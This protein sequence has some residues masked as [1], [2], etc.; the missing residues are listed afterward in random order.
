MKRIKPNEGNETFCMAPWTH[1]YLSPQTERR[2]CCASREPAQSFKQYIDTGN[3]AQEYK[4]LSLEQHWNSKHMRSVRKRMLAGER[5]P[6]CE[7]CDNKLLNTNVYRSYWNKLFQH[8]IDEAFETTKDT[9]ETDMRT[10]SFDYRFNNLCNFKCR[11]CGDMLSSSWEAETRKHKT[12]NIESHPWMASPLKEQIKKF[13]DGQVIREFINAIENKSIREIYWCGGEPLMWD[14]HWKSML[15]IVDLGFSN[16][17]YV[18]YNTNLSRV[19]FGKTKLFD[20]LGNFNDWQVC[21]S[22]DGTGAVGEYIRD[23]LNYKQWLENF[24]QGISVSRNARQM[25]L[26]FTITMPGLLELKNMFDL[27]QELNTEILT[28]VMFTFSNDE[29]LSPLSLPEKLLH[30][31]IDEALEYME[32][33]ATTKQ[34]SLIDVLKNLKNRQTFVPSKKGKSRQEYIDKI[35]K[36]DIK[37]ILNKDRR[38]LDWWTSI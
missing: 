15:R 33:K 16:E 21:A 13:Q 32:P 10:I 12:W 2:M 24:R 5:L 19:S 3:D 30:S 29:I 17:V 27:S 6:E 35:R 38:I 23:G 36:Q 1:T 26:D 14:T 7:V 11:M 18:R 20:L 4:P 22:I 37:N 31:I 9:G 28:K 25:R 34:K 8:K